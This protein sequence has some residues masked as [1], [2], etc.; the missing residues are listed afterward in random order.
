MSTLLL[1]Y[2]EILREKNIIG[3]SYSKHRLKECFKGYFGADI[4]F[5]SQQVK[6]RNCIFECTIRS[7]S[8]KQSSSAKDAEYLEFQW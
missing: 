5:P 3:E 1:K 2:Q 8:H 4:I 7:R 6:A